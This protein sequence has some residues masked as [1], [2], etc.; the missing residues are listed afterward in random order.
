[1]TYTRHGHHIPGT[2]YL[3]SVPAS[4]IGNCGGPHSDTDC[5][6][7][8]Q[9]AVAALADQDKRVKDL[10]SA[11]S[12]TMTEEVERLRQKATELY[13]RSRELSLAITKLD[14][15]ELWLIKCQLLYPD[16]PG[17]VQDQPQ[18][19]VKEQVH[20]VAVRLGR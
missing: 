13:P 15:F 11:V 14:E 20:D 2:P 1:M 3:A 5:K 17:Y 12:L 8:I 10:A 4:E 9:D 19:S 7:C 18:Q 6:P 16:L